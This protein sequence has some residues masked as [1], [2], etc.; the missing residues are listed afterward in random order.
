MSTE[1]NI[2]I[3][4][5]IDKW[6]FSKVRN[7]NQNEP[8][9]Q[10]AERVLDNY[11][12]LKGNLNP[13]IDLNILGECLDIKVKKIV[14]SKNI[15]SA[16]LLVP[17]NGGFKIKLKNED[18][19][20]NTYKERYSC[21]HEMAHTF[22]YEMQ[23]GGV[24]FRVVPGGSKYE[25]KICDIAAAEFLMPKESFEKETKRLSK[26]KGYVLSTLL[27]LK[28]KFKTSLNSVSIRL[29]SDLDSAWSNYLIAKWNPIFENNTS[30]KIM[31]FKKEW[32]VSKKNNIHLP[33]EVHD[34]DDVI[35][36]ILT[37]MANYPGNEISKSIH[38]NDF[39]H[40]G[41]NI[42]VLL[43]NDGFLKKRS[44][45]LMLSIKDYLNAPKL[46]YNPSLRKNVGISYNFEKKNLEINNI[47]T[48][49]AGNDL[50]DFM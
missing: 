30:M 8:I 11:R 2:Q 25:E 24:P 41:V 44:F 45:L 3:K 22:F 50:V 48:K 23:D 6:L 47:S 14:L 35:F 27:K 4:A 12:E 39:Y 49:K 5:R 46:N 43:F 31:G 9:L 17:I 21:A 20:Y 26:E 1:E 18:R 28:E 38:E 32:D 37:D 16:A 13:P 19:L 40:E 15:K 42:K 36:E 34:D 7:E 10:L 29:V 33:Q